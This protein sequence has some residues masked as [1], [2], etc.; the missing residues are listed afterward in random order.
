[1]ILNPNTIGA[2]EPR[3]STLFGAVAVLALLAICLVGSVRAEDAAPK[4]DPA[5]AADGD[6]PETAPPAGKPGREMPN[7]TVVVTMS[8]KLEKL[9]K[10]EVDKLGDPSILAK[11]VVGKDENLYV[12][13]FN[14]GIKAEVLENIDTDCTMKGKILG[15]G[16]FFV[17][18]DI[19]RAGPENAYT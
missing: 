4:T 16:Q 6:K 19:V 13:A 15:E 9:T 12:K 5:P 3:R 17:V 1:M 7:P 14:D 10:A 11:F 2:L 8:G 18:R